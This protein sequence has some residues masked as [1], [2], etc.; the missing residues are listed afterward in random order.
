MGHTYE[1]PASTSPRA[2][3]RSSASRTRCARRS[4]PRS[5]ATSVASAACS[6]SPTHR[7]RHPVL[8]SSTDGVGT[9]ALIAQADGPVRHD[10]HRPRRHVRRRHRLPGRRAAVLPRLHRGRQARP[11]PHRRSSSRASPSGCRQAGCALIGGEM[12]EHPGA[13]EPGEFDL[14]G[15]AVGVVERDRLIT[16]ADVRARRRRSSG[17]RRPGLRSN[18][19][20]LARRVLLESAGRRSTARPTR[21]RTTRWPTSS[22]SRRSST[23]RPS[24][25]CC[26][27]STCAPSPTS[28]AAAS[29]ATSHGCSPDGVDAVVDA[30]RVGGAADLRR[31]PAAR[32]RRATTRWRRCST[33]ASA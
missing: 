25:R 2:R 15:F 4:G 22:S 11:R 12:A 14:V 9:K 6:R 21:V 10:R 7:F 16:G 17:C 29:P 20:S 32:R 30:Q 23:R 24:P 13:M 26:G 3:R 28:P 18:G 27:R 8:V 1:A 33:S 31:D 19:Y 5:S